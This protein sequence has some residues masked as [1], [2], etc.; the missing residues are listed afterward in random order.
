MIHITGMA[1]S[2]KKACFLHSVINYC[3]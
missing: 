2:L 3:A 1:Y